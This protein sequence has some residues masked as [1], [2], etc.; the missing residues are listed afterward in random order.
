MLYLHSIMFILILQVFTNTI[1]VDL[2]TFHYVYI[3]TSK[4]HD[5]N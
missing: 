4:M 1:L 5:S 3:N 2:F